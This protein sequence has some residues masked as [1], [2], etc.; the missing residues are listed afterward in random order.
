MAVCYTAPMDRL[1]PTNA[2]ACYP[3][4]DL[5]PDP[6]QMVAADGTIVFQNR[7]MRALFG[8]LCGQICWQALK[9]TDAT[10]CRTC[11]R[12]R[13]EQDAF[14]D[15]QVEVSA[16]NG[17]RYLVSHSALK[18][19][20]APHLIEI[21]KDVTEFRRLLEEN[22]QVT[23]GVAVAREVQNKC[24]AVAQDVPGFTVNWR[25]RPSHLIAG[26]FLNVHYWQE[27]YL[28]AAVADVAGHGIGAAAVTFLLKTVY[29]QLCRE[30]LGMTDFARTLQRRLHGYLLPGQFITLAL[31][32]IDTQ[33][34]TGSVLNA[35]HPPVLHFAAGSRAPRRF[36]AQ[37]LPLGVTPAAGSV[38]ATESF[39][40]APGDRLLLYTDGA[41]QKFN[42]SLAAFISAATACTA[43]SPEQSVAALLPADAAPLEDD[44]TLLLLAANPA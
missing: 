30:R 24:I 40:L 32:L 16:R 26:D 7:A 25:Y 29:D 10:E 41:F 19:D 9:G 18:I 3:V 6:L 37:L 14:R 36:D 13:L 2:G 43:V 21:Y 11:P 23:A 31:V 8:D 12:R 15:E 5:L 27:R 38:V 22:A 39:A 33:T 20:G 34:M 44:L 17:R 28:A 35:G 4:L 1:V 42:R